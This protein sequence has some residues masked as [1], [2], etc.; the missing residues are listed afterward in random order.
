[1]LEYF[2]YFLV[3]VFVILLA[4][5]PVF[6]RIVVPTNEVHIVQSRR[7]TISYG[8]GMTHGNTY[9]AWPSWIPVIGI[10][11]VSLPLSVIDI[12][13][14]GYE[15]YDQGRVPFVIDIKA[16][17]RISDS[18]TAAERI[19]TLPELITQLTAILQGAARS[20]LASSQIEE[21]MQGRSKFG[22]MFTEAVDSQ[23]TSWGVQTVKSIELMD[24]RDSSNSK[25]IANIMEKQK[26]AIEMESRSVVAN[27]NKKAQVAEI[28][29]KQ[30]ADIKKQEAEQLVGIRTA[31]KTQA[32]GIADEKAQQEIKE[33]AKI[34]AE[35]DM[36][37][38]QVQ[39]V[40]Q[41]EITRDVQVV[42][43]DQ[44]KKTIVIIAEGQLEATK[45]E[46]EGVLV[47]AQ[48]EAQAIKAKGEAS[49]E[50]E[51]LMQLAAVEP[52]ITLAKEIGENAGYQDYLIKIRVVEKDQVVGT[53][54]AKAL[55]AAG[56]K[57][58]A[59]TGDPVAG[60]SSVMDLF[61]AKGG[62]SAGAMLDAFANTEA[63]SAVLSKLGVNVS[64]IK[65][66][67][68]QQ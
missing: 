53:E 24:I 11:H 42:A 28:L 68:T 35:K 38:K 6:L 51:K 10:N 64:D 44:E 60:V 18:S 16:F 26:S 12:N 48:N 5:I 65:S 57:I 3:T 56:I 45:R 14:N 4:L 55:Q 8:K 54:Q 67:M 32:V 33:Q 17:F 43:A 41:A 19:S 58:I 21:I 25:V 29:A 22:E 15:A 1:M 46:A 23:L 13:L 34:T 49:A 59:N 61:S 50:A 9:Y 40:K 63:G 2:I 27:N 31:E 47:A 62:T 66:L 37:V 7:E 52:Q 39:E 20:I 36:A 30:E